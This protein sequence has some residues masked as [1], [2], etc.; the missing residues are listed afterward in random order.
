M[1]IKKQ[2]L[3]LTSATRHLDFI[4]MS[5]FGSHGFRISLIEPFRPK[6]QH[7]YEMKMPDGGRYYGTPYFLLPTLL[8]F[9]HFL[10]N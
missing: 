5:K 6:T 9:I 2:S 1:K 10:E 4:P 3:R 8:V 7:G